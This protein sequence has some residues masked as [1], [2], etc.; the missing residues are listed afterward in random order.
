MN[1]PVDDVTPAFPYSPQQQYGGM[2]LRDYFAAH[3]MQAAYL[4]YA[5]ETETAKHWTIMGLAESAYSMADAMIK[6]RSTT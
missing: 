4:V 1:T 5:N 6:A 3:A 2:T